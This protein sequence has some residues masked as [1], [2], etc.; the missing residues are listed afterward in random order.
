MGMGEGPRHARLKPG[1][2]RS[3]E[4][5]EANQLARLRAAMIELVDEHGFEG[6]PLRWVTGRAEVSSRTFY[7]HFKGKQECLLATS[8]A[9]ML[10]IARRVVEESSGAADPR[11]ALRRGL[12]S[13]LDQL[14]EDP[15]AG[16]LALVEA[17]A[18]GLAFVEQGREMAAPFEESLAACL[19]R[20]PGGVATP[21]VVKAVTAG[22]LR[23]VRARLL[24]GRETE[25]PG[26][27][28]QLYAWVMLACSRTEDGLQGHASGP[29]SSLDRSAELIDGRRR[30]GDEDRDRH[31][32]LSAALKLAARDGYW[33]IS[34]AT[35]SAEAGLPPKSFAVRFPD[36]DSCYLASQQLLTE[37]MLALAAEEG[38]R[39]DSWAEGIHRAIA[40]LAVSAAAE[41][42]LA[43]L[44]FLDISLPGVAGLRER[45]RLLGV[46]VEQF[47][48]SAP[49][50]LR[51]DPIAA[52]A[53]LG[54]IWSLMRHCVTGDGSE[55]LPALAPFLTHLALAPAIGPD[56]AVDLISGRRTRRRD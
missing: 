29:G 44:A 30:P 35:V 32:L 7:E 19:T 14:A 54:A 37:R 41:P 47:L 34:G 27:V 48:A 8:A 12:R 22:V 26:L 17:A 50:A 16:R 45:L 18:G 11:D 40:V 28:D 3:R 9:I 39:A 51:P 42:G 23:V 56:A 5:V 1:P 25:L 43:K 10:R 15:P 24:D 49:R 6:V 13:F 21:L 36:V 55:G 38:T 4:E 20:I 2:G 33:R 53:S 46:I 31:L 52:E